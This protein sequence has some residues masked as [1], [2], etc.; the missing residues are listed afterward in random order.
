MR[1]S[2]VERVSS[3]AQYTRVARQNSV[4]IHMMADWLDSTNLSQN[5]VWPRAS[6]PWYRLM[7]ISATQ[8]DSGKNQRQ[9]FQNQP[10]ATSPT[11]EPAR[12]ACS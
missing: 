3:P 9:G 2:M 6:S 12:M 8:A 1:D 4:H 11:A 7:P 10:S 5:A